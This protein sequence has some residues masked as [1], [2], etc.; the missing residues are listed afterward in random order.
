MGLPEPDRVPIIDYL[1]WKN[2]MTSMLIQDNTK[3]AQ[4]PPMD[5]REETTVIPLVQFN[6]MET[7]K[8]CL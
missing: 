5:P 2:H 3:L 4:P 7:N 6:H 8:C 1:A